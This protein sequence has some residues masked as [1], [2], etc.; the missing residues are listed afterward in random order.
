[1][2]NPTRAET[3]WS[4]P[5]EPLYVAAFLAPW[6]L[7]SVFLPTHLRAG[8]L[9]LLVILGALL[10]AAGAWTRR[11]AERMGLDGAQWSFAAVVSLGA[12]I[13]VLILWGPRAGERLPA[14]LCDE[15]GRGG[16]MHEPFCLG[17]GAR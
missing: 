17:C 11:R 10:G 2:T 1:M 15:C 3:G 5:P 14:W 16:A 13:P 4:L 6:A 8:F 9:I 7:V 12:A